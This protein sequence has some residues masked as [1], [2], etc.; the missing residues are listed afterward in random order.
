MIRILKCTASAKCAIGLQIATLY[1]HLISFEFTTITRDAVYFYYSAVDV[2]AG[3][4]DK[5]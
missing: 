4:Y 5:G 2:Y 1:C 3:E